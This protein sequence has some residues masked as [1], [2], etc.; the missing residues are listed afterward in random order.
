ML[1]NDLKLR[2]EGFIGNSRTDRYNIMCSIYAHEKE[3]QS[4]SYDVSSSGGYPLP[5]TSTT[6][7]LDSLGATIDFINCWIKAF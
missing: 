1:P 3:H 6:E 7:V 2:I 4:A 5:T